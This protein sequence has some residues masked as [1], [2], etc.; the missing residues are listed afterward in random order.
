MI[1]SFV[2]GIDLTETSISEGFYLQAA[3]LLKQELETVA[4]LVEVRGG[5]R[6]EKRTPNVGVVPWNLGQLYGSLNEA[7]HVSE[8]SV[9]QTILGMKQMGSALPVAMEPGYRKETAE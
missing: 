5:K 9:L 2:Q 4:A 1:A 6:N 7:A 3:A 8:S